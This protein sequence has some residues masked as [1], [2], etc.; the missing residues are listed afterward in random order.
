MQSLF[1]AHIPPCDL[2]KNDISLKAL[3]DLFNSLK[4]GKHV[5]ECVIATYILNEHKYYK[6]VD[7]MMCET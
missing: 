6:I 3:E 2:S 4:G 5:L 7:T 1:F